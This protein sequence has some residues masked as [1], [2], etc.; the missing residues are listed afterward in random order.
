MSS[1]IKIFVHRTGDD[2]PV[3]ENATERCDLRL[4]KA[5]KALYMKLGGTDWV[6]RMLGAA[7]KSKT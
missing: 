7:R 3:E 5:D 1:R 6:R 4:S 2:R